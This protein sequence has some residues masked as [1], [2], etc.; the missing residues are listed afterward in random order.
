[1]GASIAT[2]WFTASAYQ[3]RINVA[4]RNLADAEE[5]LRAIRARREAGTASDL[6]VSQ[7]EALVAGVRAGIPALQSNVST[8]LY[9]LAVL[10]GE[11]PEKLDL[12][13]GSLLGLSLPDVAPGLPSELLRRRPDIAAA[14]A[15]LEAAR[16]NLR[17][18]RA[19]LYP[20]VTLTGSGGNS[21]ID[22]TGGSISLAGILSGGGDFIS[23][24]ILPMELAVKAL[25]HLLGK[26]IAL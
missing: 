14:E 6:D 11:T 26:Q 21:T 7:Q 24:P 17:V 5:I 2:T 13:P 8:N 25:A 20:D 9:A 19:A 18:A 4:R 12:Q 10:V 16:A 22:T 15:Q 3:D 1:M 23:K